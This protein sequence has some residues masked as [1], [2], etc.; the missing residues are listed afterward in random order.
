MS[1]QGQKKDILLRVKLVFLGFILFAAC[2]LFSIGKVQITEGDMWRSK[3]QAL[4]LRFVEIEPMRG[5]IYACDGSLLATSLPRYDVHIDIMAPVITNSIF[6]E[7]LD[8]LAYALS[9]LFGDKTQS[10][11]K[12][13]LRQARNEKNR[14]FLIKRNIS[15]DQRNQL[16]NFP[17]FNLKKNNGGLI[18]TQLSKREKPF[19]EL[20]SRTVG[21]KVKDSSVTSVGI[22][23]AFNDYLKGVRGKRLMQRISSAVW[24]PVNNENEIEPKDGNDIVTTIDINIQDVAENALLENLVLHNAKMGCAILMEVAT[25]EIKAIANLKQNEQ[26]VYE[27]SYNVAIGNAT[28]PGSTFKL[29]SYMVAMED[30]FL[31]PDDTI[32]AYGGRRKFGT[33]TIEDSHPDGISFKTVKDAFAHS[34]NVA[35]ASA[36]YKYYQKN[37]QSYISGLKKLHLDG[38]LG[39]KLSGATYHP[40]KNTGD[41]T[42]SGVSLPYMSMGYETL[43]TPMQLL[44]FYNAVANNGKMVAP[45][46]VKEIRNKSQ[47]VERFKPVILADS[48]CSQA[49]IKKAKI[50]LEEVV[51]TGTAKGIKNAQYNIAGK[52]GTAQIASLN[53]YDKKA[54]QASFCGYF[55]AENPKYSCIVVIYSPNNGKIYGSEVACPV[56]ADIAAKVFSLDVKMHKELNRMPDSLFAGFPIVK[57]GQANPTSKVIKTLSIPYEVQSNGWVGTN[58]KQVDNSTSL[59]PNVVGM[60]LS[61]AIYLL[62][63]FGLVVQPVGRGKVC[64]QSIKAGQ[65]LEKGQKIIIELI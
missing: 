21:F 61:D 15:F 40:I 47:I 34:S 43:L 7:K 26:G 48:I 36:I 50:L 22:E 9:T 38:D 10:D 1:G 2:I 37:P 28:E 55:P 4:N 23:G 54:Y 33:E 64:K 6:N 25:G 52:T 60:G 32:P 12:Q 49:T 57:S 39:I 63:S 65:K 30:G 58:L 8:S 46:F 24:K 51:K 18:I 31:N 17:I 14:Y 56:F 35:V 53:G 62:E 3:Q 41:K 29:A 13:M 59:V 20:A 11:Y 44:T 5:N 45:M 27:E 19:K 42:W 16:V